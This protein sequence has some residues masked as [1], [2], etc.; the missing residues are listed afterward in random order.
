[1]GLQLLDE[2]WT[3]TI[4]GNIEVIRREL[5]AEEVGEIAALAAEF[6]DL[7]QI[8]PT[9]SELQHRLTELGDLKLDAVMVRPTSVRDLIE[10]LKAGVVTVEWVRKRLPGAEELMIES[11][12][13]GVQST[14]MERDQAEVSTVARSDVARQ[15]RVQLPV[16]LTIV[17][18]YTINDKRRVA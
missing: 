8:R 15:D 14:T 7:R 16:D 18:D 10:L 5:D 11:T 13:T 12:P 1:M 9:I 3:K 2:G 6:P 17:K 4:H